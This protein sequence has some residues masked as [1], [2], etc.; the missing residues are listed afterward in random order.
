MMLAMEISTDYEKRYYDPSNDS[1]NNYGEGR[2]QPKV[3]W[4]NL[5]SV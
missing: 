1:E 4:N 2:N 3:W 5:C